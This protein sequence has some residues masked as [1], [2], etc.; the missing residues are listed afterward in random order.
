MKN[1]I[2]MVQMIFASIGGWIGWM[3]GGIDGFLYALI[4]FVV[5]DYLT[6]IMASILEQKL[7]SEV[8]FRG[9]FKKVLTFV[10][11]GV[12][13]IIDYYLIGSGSA[14]RTA[15]IFFYISNEG[16]SILENTAKI[17]LP[18]PDKL[19]NVLEQLKEEKKNG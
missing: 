16:I 10:L 2:E 4:A 5:I 18:I 17:G 3:L 7:S 12:A 11:V 14:I 15:V 13:H 9:I 8:G 6:G 19:R 1:I